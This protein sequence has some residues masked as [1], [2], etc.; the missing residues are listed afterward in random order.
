MTNVIRKHECDIKSMNIF[1]FQICINQTCTSMNPYIDQHTKCPS[2][3]NDM[4]CSSHGVSA[5]DRVFNIKK[6]CP[7]DMRIHFERVAH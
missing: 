6:I 1:Y 4:E 7:V 5:R 3:H 2:N